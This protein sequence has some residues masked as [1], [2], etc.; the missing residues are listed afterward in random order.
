MD[1]AAIASL[2]GDPQQLK[3]LALSQ[4]PSADAA[5]EVATQF[6]S[7]LLRQ[8]LKDALKPVF[9]GGFLKES[10]GAHD[11]YRYFFTDAIAEGVARGG[12]FGISDILQQQIMETSDHGNNKTTD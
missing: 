9:G 12:G 8:Y 11:M 6:E 3:E 2:G 4:V 10:G 1:T 5:K 7:L